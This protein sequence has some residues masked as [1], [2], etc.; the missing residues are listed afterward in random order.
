MLKGCMAKINEQNIL[1]YIH[2]NCTPMLHHQLQNSTTETLCVTQNTGRLSFT[3]LACT[4]QSPIITDSN[5]KFT[6]NNA[7]QKTIRPRIRQS[8]L[9]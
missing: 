5:T 6:D 1:Y 8:N 9:E 3:T 7:E 4:I 2:M